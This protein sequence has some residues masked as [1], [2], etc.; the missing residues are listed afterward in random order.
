MT[1]RNF[2]V[3]IM[4]N[5]RNAALYMGATSDL[6]KCVHPRTENCF[7]GCKQELDAHQL[8]YYEHHNTAELAIRRE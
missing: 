7:E 1:E 3:Y 4:A 6:V 2:Y 5:K 8:V